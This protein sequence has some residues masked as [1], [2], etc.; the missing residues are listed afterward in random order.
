M[1]IFTCGLLRNLILKEAVTEG[2]DKKF[3]PLKTESEE[4]GK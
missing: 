3:C 1:N 4:T 2:S